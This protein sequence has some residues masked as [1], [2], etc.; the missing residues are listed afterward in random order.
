MRSRH[1]NHVQPGEG[2]GL[3]LM[4]MEAFTPDLLVTEKAAIRQTIGLSVECSPV[5]M[6]W[7]SL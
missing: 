1:S 3:V 5:K 6:F 2:E 4:D 7:F